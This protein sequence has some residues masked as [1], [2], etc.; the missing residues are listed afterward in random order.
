MNIIDVSWPITNDITEYKDKKYID[1][2]QLKTWD[3]DKVRESLV[4]MKSH[5]G[6]HIDAPSHFLENGKSVDSISL[7]DLIGPCS[8]IDLTDVLDVIT[9]ENLIPYQDIL[10]SS[11]IV[12]FKTKNSARSSEEVFDFNFVYLDK[13][14]AEYIQQ[15]N[16]KVIG[17][18]YLGIE[19]KI[20]SLSKKSETEYLLTIN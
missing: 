14:A 16:L 15:S 18:D 20:E 4:T 10:Q 5:T 7:N 11:D 8:V 9:K 3:K 19:G 12:L 6:T 13:T 1:I 2:Q 17:F